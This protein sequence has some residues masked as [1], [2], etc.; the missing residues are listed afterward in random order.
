MSRKVMTN[1]S[2]L[3]VYE[4]RG[5][6]SRVVANPARGGRLRLRVAPL[7]FRSPAESLHRGDRIG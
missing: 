6:P 2:L 4:H 1:D 7:F 3:Q 5:V